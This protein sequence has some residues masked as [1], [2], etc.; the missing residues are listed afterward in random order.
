[1][2][3]NLYKSFFPIPY[4][5]AM[6]SFGVDISDESIKYVELINTQ[7]GIKVGKFGEKIIPIGI[8]ESGRIKE[9]KKL[10]EILI[11][12]RKEI[13]LKS[14]RV[15]LPEEQVYL[16]KLRLE[17]AGLKSIREGIEFLIEEHVPIK[18]EDII[19]DYEILSEDSQGIEVE[20]AAI[21]K[22]I[23]KIYLSVFENA[24]I[25]TPSFELEDQ[26]RARTII[27]KGDFETYMIVDFGRKRTGISVVSNGTVMFASTLDVGGVLLTNL[28]QKNFNI[29]FEEAEKMKRQYGLQRNAK[30]KEM[31]S[32]LLNGVSILRDEIEKH[33]LYWHTHK[34]EEGKDRPLIKKIILCGG[35]SNLIGLSEYLAVTIKN[36]V[37]IAN[38]WVN[39]NETQES[40]PE[41][42]FEKSLSFA[43]A[44][45]LALGDFEN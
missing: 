10:E 5:L 12:L 35:D 17:K 45:G 26:A 15:S 25:E 20:V 27:K 39:I 41:I 30:N 22:E 13:G 7:K 37:E 9:Q 31:F 33:F 6:P 28:I 19:F 16:F 43:A 32:I 36:K 29:S 4:F 44:L 21:P 14:A 8:I 3:R 24:S 23:I 42:N 34:N 18:I 1:M 40:I 2:S 11:S 38:V